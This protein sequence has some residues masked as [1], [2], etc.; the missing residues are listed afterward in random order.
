MGNTWVVTGLHRKYAELIEKRSAGRLERIYP[1]LVHHFSQA[2]VPDKT[3]EYGVKLAQK[4]LDTFSPE[5]AIR[6]SKIVLEYLE[7]EE[8]AGDPSLEGHTRLLLAEGQRM[9]GL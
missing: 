6:V 5:E 4:S 3:V 2:D 9:A 7:D 1:E 8:W